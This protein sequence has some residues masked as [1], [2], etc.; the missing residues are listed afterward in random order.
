MKIGGSSAILSA[1]SA[2]VTDARRHLSFP[3]IF[4]KESGNTPFQTSDHKIIFLKQPMGGETAQI[5]RRES[6]GLRQRLGQICGPK[7]RIYTGQAIHVCIDREQLEGAYE[8][9]APKLFDTQSPITRFKMIN[10]VAAE[11][12]ESLDSDAWIAL[13]LKHDDDHK[14]ILSY[15]AE[16]GEVLKEAEI[17]AGQKPK[18]D[19]AFRDLGGYLSYSQGGPAAT[20]RGSDFHCWVMSMTHPDPASEENATASDHESDTLSGISTHWKY[21]KPPY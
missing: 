11:S 18:T 10:A 17:K 21:F 15:L 19:I 16:L 7:I 20:S 2:T 3:G 5:D 1:S 6:G 14:E 9:L 13:C 12:Y 4:P 8:R